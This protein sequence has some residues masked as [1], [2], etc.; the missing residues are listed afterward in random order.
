[1]KD[2]QLSDLF[3][4]PLRTI[5]DWKKKGEGDWRL[6]IYNFLKLN[7]NDG[8]E[9]VLTEREIQINQRMGHLKNIFGER[10]ENYKFESFDSLFTKEPELLKI[11]LLSNN[12]ELFCFYKARATVMLLEEG[13]ENEE[14]KA[15]FSIMTKANVN[16][17]IQIVFE[18]Q[19]WKS[20]K[21]VEN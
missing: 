15:A 10:L 14:T 1:M 5:A 13:L 2:T 3:G 9:G 12:L 11:R 21:G 6:K 4:L 7:A 8:P 17:Y 19:L 18:Y 20:K 16:D